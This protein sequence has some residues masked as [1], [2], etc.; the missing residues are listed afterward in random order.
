MAVTPASFRPGVKRVG[1][2]DILSSTRTGGTSDAFTVRLPSPI[3]DVTAISAYEIQ[4]PKV[5]YN[6]FASGPNQ[7]NTLYYNVGA[8]TASVTIPAG[9][10]TANSLIAA[11]NAA[12]LTAGTTITTNFS[13]TTFLTTIT[14]SAGTLALPFASSTA[15]TI[16][17]ILGFI[18]AD[19]SGN[20]GY[21]STNGI[22][23]DDQLSIYINIRGISA[24]STTTDLLAGYAFKIAMGGNFPGDLVVW[25]AEDSYDARIDVPKQEIGTLVINITDSTGQ[26]VNML[27][28]NW[29]ML[30]HVYSA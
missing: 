27:G 13:S 9:A 14:T 19:L 28:Y 23:L 6:I 17:Q 4:M 11:L 12:L 2:I 8:G 1:E 7:N 21:T 24:G 25:R 20:T 3:R 18:P 15:G 5:F 29:S 22:N 30:L 16:A 26:Q 10:Y